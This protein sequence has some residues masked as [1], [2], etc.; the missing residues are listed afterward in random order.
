V[1]TAALLAAAAPAAQAQ[2][3][4]PARSGS[5]TDANVLAVAVGGFVIGPSRLALVKI[6]AARGRWSVVGDLTRDATQEEWEA[7]ATQIASRGD[8]V[9][10]AAMG[11]VRRYARSGARGVFAELGGGAA[12]AT[13]TVT[14]PGVADVGRRGTVPL[15]AWGLG[16]RSGGPQ[17]LG[18]VELGFR[19]G[20][21]LATRH[22]YVDG[23]SP[24]GSTEQ[25]VSYRS[26]YLGAGQPTSQFY[27]ALGLRR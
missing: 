16:W 13:L 5:G 2:T 6:E 20:V 17:A 22:L 26:W 18:F 10:W 15:A 1:L 27:I 14:E 4:P 7:S 12:R 23:A 11:A 3:V 19:N 24:P 9:A 21:G 8:Y 25:A